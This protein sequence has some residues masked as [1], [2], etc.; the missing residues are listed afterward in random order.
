MMQSHHML[1]RQLLNEDVQQ[2]C[3]IDFGT[4]PVQVNMRLYSLDQKQFNL[5]VIGSSEKRTIF[6]LTYGAVIS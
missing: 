1:W 5:L 3:W 4:D 6:N 2:Q